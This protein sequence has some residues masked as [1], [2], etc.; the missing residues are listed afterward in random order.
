MPEGKSD[1]LMEAAI[2]AVDAAREDLLLAKAS[3]NKARLRRVAISMV[4]GALLAERQRCIKAAE[5]IQ[6]R[7]DDYN[8]AFDGI[9]DVI[10]AIRTPPSST[11]ER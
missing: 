7:S 1:D 9:A 8:G 10:E 2:R 3:E 6:T 11:E 5:A 4:H